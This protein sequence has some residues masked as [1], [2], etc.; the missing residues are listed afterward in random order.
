MFQN[1]RI[2]EKKKEKEILHNNGMKNT[3]EKVVHNII[4][5]FPESD[6]F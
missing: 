2:P 4:S 3:V 1:L 5:K 6:I